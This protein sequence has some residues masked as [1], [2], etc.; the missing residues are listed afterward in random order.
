MK[1]FKNSE[2]YRGVRLMFIGKADFSF[3]SLSY[4]NK[5]SC[6]PIDIMLAVIGDERVFKPLQQY[7]QTMNKF[8]LPLFLITTITFSN[9]Q[10][11]IFHEEFDNCI[12]KIAIDEDNDVLW[13]GTGLIDGG[14]LIMRDGDGNRT[15]ISDLTSN[16]SF[17]SIS[18]L[19]MDESTLFA[20]GLGGIAII[21]YDVEVYIQYTNDNS[22]LNYNNEFNSM[23]FDYNSDKLYAGNVV[24]GTDILSEDGW[25]IDNTLKNITASAF[26]YEED[27]LWL[28]NTSGDLIRIKDENRTIFNSTNSA[29]PDLIYIDMTLDT[30]GNIYL[31]VPDNGF[32]HFDGTNAQHYTPQNSDLFGGELRSIDIDN[33]GKVWFAHNGGITSFQNG[34]FNTYPLENALGFFPIVQDIVVDNENHLWLGACGGLIEFFLEPTSTYQQAVIPLTIFPNPSNGNFMFN[35]QEKG[36]LEILNLSGQTIYSSPLIEGNNAIQLDISQGQYLYHF[37]GNE[38]HHSGKFVVH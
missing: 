31:L 5:N 35:T 32:V 6:S 25:S 16:I 37:I 26:D 17:Q 2:T 27:C 11:V 7:F 18:T 4:G 15:D 20:G 36:D 13:M 10:T 14:N 33:N 30:E 34:V 38:A 24:T 3:H 28:A 29:V 23:V 9:A 22:D 19:F 12:R 8:L 1:W 21:D